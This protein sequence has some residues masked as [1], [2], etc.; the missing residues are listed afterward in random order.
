MEKRFQFFVVEALRSLRNNFATTV[1]ATVTVVIV[2]FFLGVFLLIGSLAYNK[3]EQQRKEVRVRVYLTDRALGDATARAAI[4]ARLKG[5][6]GVR[7]VR[8]VS[9]EQARAIMKRRLPEIV[10]T[11]DGSSSPFPAEWDAYLANP[12]DA[13]TVADAVRG[14]PGVDTPDYGQ[15]RTDNLLHNATIIEAVIGGLVLVLAISAVLLIANTIRLSI[16]ARRR[17]VEVMKLVGATNWFVR[18]PFMI[19]GLLCGIL[20][21]AIAIS[22][23]G[24]AYGYWLSDFLKLGENG[25]VQAVAFWLLAIVLLGAGALLGGMGSALTMRRFL[26]V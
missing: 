21:A 4:G 10:S 1:A 19:E 22:L 3:V 7:S 20:G 12:D 5:T 13:K 23:L 11:L 6:P 2:L 18:L 15:K 26:R 9:P 14:M 25:G 17:E 24:A 16:F 8:Y